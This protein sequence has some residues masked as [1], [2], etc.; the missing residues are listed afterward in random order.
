VLGVGLKR[1]LLRIVFD[2]GLKVLDNI[3]GSCSELVLFLAGK[4][5][6]N[7]MLMLYFAYSL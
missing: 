7:F 6:V 2:L 4:V 3:V 5:I 1:I